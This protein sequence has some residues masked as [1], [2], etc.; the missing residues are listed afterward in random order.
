VRDPLTYPDGSIK[1]RPS[2]C[3]DQ[4]AQRRLG[5]DEKVWQG[6]SGQLVE[7][8]STN[9]HEKPSHLRLIVV[10]RPAL[11]GAWYGG[12]LTRSYSTEYFSLTRHKLLFE[13]GRLDLVEA[14]VDAHYSKTL[15][16]YQVGPRVGEWRNRLRV[17]PIHFAWTSK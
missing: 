17:D 14:S 2:S 1:D 5:S 11:G 6:L 10:D 3:G 8:L 9:P 13:S 7:Q 16:L 15:V 4:E 12:E